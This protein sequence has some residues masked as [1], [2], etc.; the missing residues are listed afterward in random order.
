MEV[1]LGCFFVLLWGGFFG[2]FGFFW[3]FCFLFLFGFVGF[4]C[5]CCCYFPEWNLASHDQKHKN[6]LKITSRCKEQQA[7]HLAQAVL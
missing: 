4:F 3:W 6:Q 2:G 5:Y 7:V 1:F